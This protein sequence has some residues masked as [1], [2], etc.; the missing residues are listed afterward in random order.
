MADEFVE[1]GGEEELI[2]EEEEGGLFDTIKKYLPLIE[3]GSSLFRSSSA[4]HC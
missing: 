2:E 4:M 1:A 3:G